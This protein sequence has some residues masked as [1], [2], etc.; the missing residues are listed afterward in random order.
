MCMQWMRCK[1]FL[2]L[3]ATQQPILFL[4]IC[5]VGRIG[6]ASTIL[7]L[8]GIIGKGLYAPKNNYRLMALLQSSLWQY[9]ICKEPTSKLSFI[10]H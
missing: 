5:Q 2:K 6:L 3:G 9:S 4:I 7:A 10:K 8:E 1:V